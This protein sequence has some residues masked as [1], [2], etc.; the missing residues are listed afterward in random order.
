MSSV[1]LEINAVPKFAFLALP[2]PPKK[3]RAAVNQTFR[4]P[5]PPVNYP[6][7]I[8]A[9]AETVH[10]GSPAPM[11]PASLPRSAS[12]IP[13][14]LLQAFRRPSPTYVGSRCRSAS[15]TRSRIPSAPFPQISHTPRSPV[16]PTPTT[17]FSADGNFDFAAFGYASIFVNVPVSTPITP[18]IHKPKPMTRLPSRNDDITASHVTKPTNTGMLR[19]L[20]GN[21]PKTVKPQTNP[22]KD[23]GGAVVS[24]Y[25]S[26]S[27]TKRAK[28]AD[29]PPSVVEK[30][31]RKV[32]GAVLPPTV[33]QE[34]Q[35][36]Q[37]MEGGSLEQN[38]HKVMEEKARREGN[39]VN[40][41]TIE[42]TKVVEG[43][44]AA[45]RDGQG[46]VW[47][48]QEEEWEFTHL[49]AS[50]KVPLSARCSNA[51][52]WVT[53]NHLKE[54]E[55]DGFSE[56]SSLPSSK[57]TDLYH[58]RP[59]VTDEAA[60]RLVRGQARSCSSVAGSIV[61][62][63][64]SLKPSNILLGIPSRPNR[65]RHL[66]P[67]FLKDVIAVPPTPSTPSAFSQT[68]SRPP[69]SPAR[70]TRFI[71][72]TPATT[73]RQR[74]RSRSLPRRQRKPA[75]P[76]LKI[77]PTCPVDKLA[78]NAGP[79]EEDTRAFLEVP[80]EAGRVTTASRSTRETTIRI[81][82][83]EIS[84]DSDTQLNDLTSVDYL[85][86]SRRLGGFFKKGERRW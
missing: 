69:R 51:E 5:N 20:L 30:K 56:L 25:R 40:V 85:K 77:I 24:N 33:K 28:Y 18:E 22:R 38:I 8:L 57:Y 10:P 76:P 13:S 17:P 3:K 41:D 2:P 52:G 72:N 62:P 36:R 29:Q 16:H 50:N 55:K 1:I 19:R 27:L 43:V 46:G 75:P 70:A 44:G 54:F 80:S 48:D 68:S 71:V 84:R 7:P 60:E 67:G 34:A 12:F 15:S 63:S 14:P 9:W 4:A 32:Y 26:V 65:G 53:F 31:K 78:V 58:S 64:P 21:K 86:K 61:L 81:P 66:Q 73:R 45:H 42:G 39:A 74:S 6:N 59:L 23:G 37:A 82:S 79:W 11:T 35:M 47:W 49:L 83:M